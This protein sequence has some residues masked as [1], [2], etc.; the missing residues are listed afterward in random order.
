MSYT[1][2]LRDVKVADFPDGANAVDLPAARTL[3]FEERIATSELEG[4]DVVV[5]VHSSVAA[6]NWTLENGGI[7]LDAYGKLT[8]RTPVAGTGEVTLSAA[9]GDSFPWLRIWG[10][11]IGD[12]GDDIHV[13]LFKCK[14]TAVSGTWGLNEFFVTACSGIAIPDGSDRIWDVVTHEADEALDITDPV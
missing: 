12:E 8:G 7:D 2:G 1:Y 14:V 4:D 13:K 5:S 6:L 3:G 11:S 9:G 10:Q